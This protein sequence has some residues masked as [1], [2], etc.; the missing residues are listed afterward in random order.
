MTNRN[1]PAACGLNRIHLITDA[2]ETEM[3]RLRT[4]VSFHNVHCSARFRT[5]PLVDPSAN[6]VRLFRHADRPPGS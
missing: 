3:T 4:A 2:L 6:L 5:V 1:Q